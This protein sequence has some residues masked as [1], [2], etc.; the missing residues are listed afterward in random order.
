M[1]G[2]G[3]RDIWSFAGGMQYRPVPPVAL[4]V[5]YNYSGNP[6]PNDL[7]MFNTAA[8]AVV[9]HHATFGVGYTF[10]NGFGLDAAYYHAFKNSISGPFQTPAGA[11]PGTSVKSSMAEN[12]FFVGFTFSPPGLP[13]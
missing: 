9:Q 4:R 8:P 2:F 6:I 5:G 11:M 3:W 12:S 13:R 7:S 10:D 1:R